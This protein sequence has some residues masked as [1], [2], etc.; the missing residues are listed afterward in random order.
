MHRTYHAKLQKTVIIL[1]PG[2]YYAG[3]TGEVIST[4]L[5]SCI[6]TCI[7]DAEHKIGGM[8]HFMLPGTVSSQNML[9]TEAG[10]YGIFA[11]ELLTGELIKLG[12]DREN[13]RAKI[14]GG[15]NV[16]GLRTSDGDI[17]QANIDFTKKF[18][19]SE[20]IPLVAEDI[21][22]NSGRKIF[23]FTDTC[24]VLVRPVDS[25]RAIKPLQKAEE[26]YK[27]T[28]LKKW[29]EGSAEDLSW[30]NEE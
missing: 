16:I 5:G 2:E 7:F 11:M 27:S 20:R 24:K 8:N 19:E 25:G 17:P 14:F 26:L 6:A 23:F 10:R 12:G 28:I 4:M 18:L 29:L 21:G 13:F 3:A 15:G 22:G 9:R 30:D 1:M